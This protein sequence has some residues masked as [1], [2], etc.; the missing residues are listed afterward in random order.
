[1]PFTMCHS[2]VANETCLLMLAWAT[3]NHRR[4]HCSLLCIP[5]LD[6]SHANAC[7]KVGQ[8]WEEQ[9]GWR[10]CQP[11]CVLLPT[12]CLGSQA[13]RLAQQQALIDLP[14]ADDQIVLGC[15]DWC[16]HGQW[17]AI[18]FLLH[19]TSPQGLSEVG[20]MEVNVRGGI[21]VNGLFISAFC[22]F[23]HML[24]F[25]TLSI[26][27]MGLYTIEVVGG[28]SKGFVSLIPLTQWLSI[29]HFFYM[30][31]YRWEPALTECEYSMQSSAFWTYKGIRYI[32]M[33][34]INNYKTGFWQGFNAKSVTSWLDTCV[35]VK[36]PSTHTSTPPH[37]LS[38]DKVTMKRFQTWL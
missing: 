11:H 28:I 10:L 30:V 1:M 27:M 38:N 31:A 8:S 17:E 3:A 32:K 33:K 35:T 20:F 34:K 25:R 12:L 14:S 22:F 4:R 19:M 26:H 6:R 5:N 15:F 23:W 29:D 13:S 9:R 18:R 21:N 16:L 24:F 7:D 2:F 36:H 37:F